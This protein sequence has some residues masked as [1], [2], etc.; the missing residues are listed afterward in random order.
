MAAVAAPAEAE[1]LGRR[2]V[3][4]KPP[5][6]G[7]H[8]DPLVNMHEVAGMSFSMTA[9]A[10]GAASG[11]SYCMGPTPVGSLADVA[12]TAYTAV[13]RIMPNVAKPRTTCTGAGCRRQGAKE[14]EELGEAGELDEHGV[15]PAAIGRPAGREH[16]VT[17]RAP[18]WAPSA[19]MSWESTDLGRDSLCCPGSQPT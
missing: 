16:D 8:A 15:V 5:G 14:A 12:I 13:L 1:R 2:V 7:V 17:R 19:R 11:A 18:G 4:R 3:Q 9:A 6:L 10:L